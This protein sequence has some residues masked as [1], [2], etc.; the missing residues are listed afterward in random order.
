MNDRRKEHRY[1]A[2]QGATVT[3]LTGTVSTSAA[4]VMDVSRSGMRIRMQSPLW[5]GMH[6]QVSTALILAA[7]PQW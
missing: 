2:N 1:P 7:R 5:A 3:V 6:I 4:V